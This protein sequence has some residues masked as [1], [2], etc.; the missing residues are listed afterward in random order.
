VCTG[1][2]A[3]MSWRRA[4]CRAGLVLTLAAASLVTGSCALSEGGVAGR[5]SRAVDGTS[6][7]VASA[8]LAVDLLAQGRSLRTTTDTAVTDALH[9]A[10]ADA[11]AI[12]LLPVRTDRDRALRDRA[13]AAVRE[14]I[15]SLT[16]ARVWVLD[17]RAGGPEAGAD[18]ADRLGDQAASMSALSDDL[19]GQE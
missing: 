2:H 11:R 9:G 13:L 10:S 15:S 3:E 19:G 4:S 16:E 6:S 17:P 14:G 8:G 18:L 12:V 5:L 1:N 7:A